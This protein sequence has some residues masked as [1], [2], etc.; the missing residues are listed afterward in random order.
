MVQDSSR[1]K[2]CNLGIKMN[3]FLRITITCQKGWMDHAKGISIYY[4]Q[5]LL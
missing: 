4:V 5:T 3:I 1:T 2:H